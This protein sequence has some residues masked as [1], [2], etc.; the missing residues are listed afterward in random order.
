MN[1]LLIVLIASTA[2]NA[3]GGE[4]KS[5]VNGIVLIATIIMWSYLFNLLAFRFESLHK[6]FHPKPKIVVKDGEIQ[7]QNLQKELITEEE[8]KG[9]L[10]RQGVDD[11]LKLKEA[12][13]ESN[14]QVSVVAYEAT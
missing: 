2:T 7:Q 14:G 10:R 3:L 6:L 13:V 9:K 1:M 4:H 5:I 11:V 8:L 12:Y